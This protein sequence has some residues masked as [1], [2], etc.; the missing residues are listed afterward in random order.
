[1]T[2]NLPQTIPTPIQSA[3][4]GVEAIQKIANIFA[5]SGLF[6]V[7]TMEQAAA[8][9]FVAQAEGLHPATAARDYHVIQ[10]RPSLK[11]DALLA[12]FQQAGGS[13]K[14]IDFTDAVVAAE[15]SHPQSGTV[16]VEWTFERAKTANLTGKDN[17]KNYPRQMLKARVISEGVRMCYPAVC[18][19]VYTPEEVMDFDEAKKSGN[20]EVDLDM[21][22]MKEADVVSQP[23]APVEAPPAPSPEDLHAKAVKN[24][25]D[26]YAKYNKVIQFPED[27]HAKVSALEILAMDELGRLYQKMDV[28]IEEY[29]ATK[30]QGVTV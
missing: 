3:A 29:I 30:K 21:S 28:L 1:M 22:A 27:I 24:I 19:G 15:F 7:K 13:I 10:G 26:A 23:A 6:G 14:W 17:W 16:K 25:G 11:A 8:L 2:M 9:M 5:K 18:A 20:A 12:R 4:Y